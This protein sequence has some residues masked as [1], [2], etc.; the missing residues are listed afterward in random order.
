MVVPAHCEGFALNVGG[1]WSRLCLVDR[2]ANTI[3]A[4]PADWSVWVTTTIAPRPRSPNRSS[5][6]TGMS[7]AGLWSCGTSAPP[8]IQVPS[9]SPLLGN[10]SRPCWTTTRSPRPRSQTRCCSR[11][12]ATRRPMGPTT[13]P[14]EVEREA[15]PDSPSTVTKLPCRAL[16]H[17]ESQSTWGTTWAASP[18]RLSRGGRGVAWGTPSSPLGLRPGSLARFLARETLA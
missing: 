18:R 16:V 14:V 1:R 7:A 13:H 12:S 2:Y 15:I 9:P 8:A 3:T 11:K 6:S 17:R 5:T 4:R 10:R